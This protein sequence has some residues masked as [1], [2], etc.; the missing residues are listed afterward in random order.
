[1]FLESRTRPVFQYFK[2]RRLQRPVELRQESSGCGRL[3]RGRLKSGRFL[4]KRSKVSN[5][6]F[7]S[8]SP[9]IRSVSLMGVNF[10]GSYARETH[11]SESRGPR[12]GCMCAALTRASETGKALQHMQ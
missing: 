11:K 12:L 1:M 8:L 3:G 2:I 6:S 7:E 4:K 5:S 10:M 9:K